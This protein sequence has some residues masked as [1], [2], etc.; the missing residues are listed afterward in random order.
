MPTPGCCP[1]TTSNEIEDAGFSFIVGSRLTK[2]PYDLA[3]HFTRHGDY[4]TDGQILESA[5]AM[6]TGKHKRRRRIVYQWSFK[7]SKRDKQDDQRTDREGGEDRRG[8]G[9]AGQDP[10][11]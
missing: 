11:P 8:Q 9:A 3:D 2:A 6:G 10:V 7:P 4:F 1:R 5:L